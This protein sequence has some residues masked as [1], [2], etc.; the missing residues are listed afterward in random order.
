MEPSFKKQKLAG[1]SVETNQQSYSPQQPSF[2]NPNFVHSMKLAATSKRR[3]WK[4]L[5]Q[6]Q[7]AEKALPWKP[8]DV[9]YSSLD[10][11]PSF[12]PA[13]KYSD[14]SGLPAKYVDPHTKLRYASADDWLNLRS[15]SITCSYEEEAPGA[16]DSS[17]C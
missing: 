3:L 17:S 16:L 8:T 10:A 7:A 4:N 9:T 2:K 5:K 12:Y 13:K 11:P 6:I 1:Q 14:I 15:A